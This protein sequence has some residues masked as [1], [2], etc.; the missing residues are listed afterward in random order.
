MGWLLALFC[1]CF[2]VKRNKPLL[3]L[4]LV[5]CSYLGYWKPIHGYISVE[6]IKLTLLCSF[7]DRGA[8]MQS[9]MDGM[10]VFSIMGSPFSDP[11]EDW[12]NLSHKHDRARYGFKWTSK[13]H[14][15]LKLLLEHKICHKR[16]VSTDFIKVKDDSTLSG[17][18]WALLWQHVFRHRRD[19]M[20]CSVPFLNDLLK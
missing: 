3:K 19:V 4:M 9:K 13:S 1:F 6:Y 17:H 18:N 2:S 10:S 7:T 20:F 15:D 5:R 11:D 8:L 16:L 14:I 12:E